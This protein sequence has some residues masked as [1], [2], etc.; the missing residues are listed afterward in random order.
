MMLADLM[1]GRQVCE[2]YA[3]GRPAV[4]VSQSVVRATKKQTGGSFNMARPYR[5]V[6]S[7]LTVIVSL[8]RIGASSEQPFDLHAVAISGRCNEGTVVQG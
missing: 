2:F 4:P 3:Q 5:H 8:I 6:Q 7:R 1:Q